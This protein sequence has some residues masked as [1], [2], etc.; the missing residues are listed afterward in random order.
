MPQNLILVFSVLCLLLC[1]SAQAQTDSVKWP[2]SANVNPV[3]VGN[4][5]GIDE[6]L[7][8]WLNVV[9]YAGTV[10]PQRVRISG[11]Y[12]G[13]SA[14]GWPASVTAELSDVYIDFPVTP[15]TG[16]DFH[17][18]SVS[19]QMIASGTNNMKANAYISTDPTFTNRTAIFQASAV[20]GQTTITSVKVTGLDTIVKS[21]KTFYVRVYPWYDNGGSASNSRY[22]CIQNVVIKGTTSAIVTKVNNLIETGDA[23]VISTEFYSITGAKIGD[24]YKTLKPG[25][26]IQKVTYSNGVVKSGKIFKDKM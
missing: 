19:L 12:T 10:I 2:L 15:A 22:I 11:T 1:F 16:F 8:S 5:T 25:M 13:Q 24:K 26:Y 20:L 21:G 23:D 7:C 17:V 18:S 3:N 4:L 6:T 9:S 14:V